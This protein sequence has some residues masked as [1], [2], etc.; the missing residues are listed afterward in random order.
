MVGFVTG[1]GTGYNGYMVLALLDEGEKVVGPDN[2]PAGFRWVAP[3]GIPLVIG[4]VGDTSLVDQIFTDHRIAAIA[5]FTAKIVVS[6]SVAD[7]PI[8]YLN[9]AANGEWEET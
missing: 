4:D 7:T 2:L 6:D 3:E 8:H 5:H 1:V 9:G